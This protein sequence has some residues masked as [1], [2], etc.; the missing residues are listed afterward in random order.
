MQ[1]QVF[2]LLSFYDYINNCFVWFNLTCSVIMCVVYTYISS[3]LMFK[4][5]VQWPGRRLADATTCLS[6]WQMQP[7]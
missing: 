7:S 5:E 1:F 6:V 3:V 4:H 2:I